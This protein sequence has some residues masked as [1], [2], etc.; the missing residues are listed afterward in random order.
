MS[1]VIQVEVFSA[2]CGIV[3][4]GVHP[5]DCREQILRFG[6]TLHNELLASFHPI[7]RLCR[8]CDFLQENRNDKL[9]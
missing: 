2:A 5:Y 7:N 6:K 9:P 4:R 8:L 1:R 3:L